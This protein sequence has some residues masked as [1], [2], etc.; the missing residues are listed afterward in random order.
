MS[1]LFGVQSSAGADRVMV[2]FGERFAASEQFDVVFREGMAL[3]E[4]VASYLDGAGRKE[5]KALK[6][7]VSVL[8]ATESMRLTTRLLDLA[9]WLLI[10]RALK[11][12]EINQ[13]EARRKRA[14]VK[15]KALGRPGHI[16]GFEDLPEALQ[17][18]VERSFALHDRIVMLDKSIASQVSNAA[19]R[20]DA[21]T[22][23]D[24]TGNPVL[25]QMSLL[26]QAFGG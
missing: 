2:S 19:P 5:A 21:E 14:R 17:D 16:K 24:T 12:G 18:L 9:S 26:R 25:A 4:E 6:P 3:V 8:Y 10:R 15:L 22:G 1:E 7:P 11:E 20:H 23:A 13:E